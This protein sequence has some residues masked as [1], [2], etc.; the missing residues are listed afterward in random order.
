MVQFGVGLACGLSSL[1][2]GM[3]I[4]VSGDSCVRAYS[5]QP[6][7]LTG[8]MLIMIFSEMIGL[9]G[10]I[11]AMLMNSQVKGVNCPVQ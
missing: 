4:G 11:M 5:R 10:V 9:F 2:A 6:R 1:A 8:F 3:A 7:F